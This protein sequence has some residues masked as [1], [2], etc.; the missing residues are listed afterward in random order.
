LDTV[1]HTEM[2]GKEL[3]CMIERRSRRGEVD[4]DEREEL[5]ME[6][7]RRFYARRR[8]E[9][10]L[11]WLDYHRGA[12]ERARRNLEALVARHEAAAEMLENGYRESA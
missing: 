4:A 6:S 12:A 11:A 8:E 5:W 9:N 2:V 1:A 10:R 3:D 7:T